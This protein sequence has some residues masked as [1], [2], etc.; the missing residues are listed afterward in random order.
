MEPGVYR[1]F[2][3]KGKA[4]Q[5]CAVATAC[6]IR[7]LHSARSGLVP[8]QPIGKL[9]GQVG[10][11]ADLPCGVIG[12]MSQTHFFERLKFCARNWRRK[13]GSIR[14]RTSSPSVTGSFI[15]HWLAEFTRESYSQVFVARLP[16]VAKLDRTASEGVFRP[17]LWVGDQR[18]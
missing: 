15:V 12:L 14:A 1:V 6:A 3:R 7:P 17:D 13:V 10:A 11:F 4:K 5:R 2:C 8:L 18:T 16:P 9:Y